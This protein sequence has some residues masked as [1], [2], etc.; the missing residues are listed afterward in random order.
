MHFVLEGVRKNDDLLARYR[1]LVDEE[2][3][4]ASMSEE[5]ALVETTL[6]RAAELFERF[7]ENNPTSEASK[8]IAAEHNALVTAE[9]CDAISRLGSR[10]PL[11]T[12]MRFMELFQQEQTDFIFGIRRAPGNPRYI[13]GTAPEPAIP[14]R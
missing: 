1:A 8:A 11:R 12:T 6:T 3:K 13:I 5:F 2:Q 10:L 4:A 9:L 14:N 7:D